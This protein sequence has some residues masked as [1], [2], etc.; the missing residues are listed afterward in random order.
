MN[1]NV[2]PPKR[3]L[4]S[5]YRVFPSLRRLAEEIESRALPVRHKERHEME[6]WRSLMAAEG[7][8]K[9]DHYAEFYTHHFGLE[10]EFYRGKRILDIGCGPRGS[11]EWADMAAERI[12]LDPLARRYADELGASRHRM[13][14]LTARSEAVPFEDGYFD[15]VCSLNSLDH[16][17]DL[18]R[19]IGEIKR[20][21]R[22][23]G[24]FLLISEVNHRP[25]P[26]EPIEYGWDITAR[27][28]DAFELLAEKRYEMG[29]Q[30]NVYAQIR[31][32]YRWDKAD[33]RA[34]SGILT[35][36]FRRR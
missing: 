5:L 30:H 19:T 4:R 35:A 34:R 9:N 24:L 14:Y 6:Y 23:G 2:P 8:L 20:V 1:R 36:K 11:L 32:N 18:N 13:K 28:A 7:C 31:A 25:T 10:P 27:F 21:C 17:A 29:G 22:A 16:V 15:V 26:T 33:T 12:G 3:A